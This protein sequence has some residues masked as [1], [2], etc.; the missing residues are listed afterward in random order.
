[1]ISR[2]TDTQR[3]DFLD[4]IDTELSSYADHLWKVQ[5]NL[6]AIKDVS[7]KW[8]AAAQDAEKLVRVFNGQENPITDRIITKELF[9]AGMS[10]EEMAEVSRRCEVFARDVRSCLKEVDA[11]LVQVKARIQDV[12]G[13]RDAV[14]KA[15]G[16]IMQS[17]WQAELNRRQSGLG[18]T[19]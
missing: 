12:N 14:S 9:D 6:E 10:V 18:A 5:D 16:I 11:L 3:V 17:I 19:P 15:R 1:M 4:S 2:L 7:P 13:W 8:L